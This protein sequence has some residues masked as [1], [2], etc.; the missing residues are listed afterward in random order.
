MLATSRVK[1]LGCL[2]ASVVAAL[3][4]IGLAFAQQPPGRT[5]EPPAGD[6]PAAGEGNRTN[7]REGGI[8]RTLDAPRDR[9]RESQEGSEEGA[10]SAEMQPRIKEVQPR[11]APPQGDWKLGVWANNTDTGVVITRVGPRSAAASAG[12]ENGDRIV[13]IGGYQVGYVG[14][15]LF[16]LG[17]E[18]QR[19]ADSRGRVELLVQNVRNKQLQNVP[20]Q[21]DGGRRPSF[22]VRP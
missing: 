2:M 22:P 18:L 20:V 11:F 8:P 1:I 19:Q 4:S 12:L 17:Y 9:G 14:D 16:P 13:A 10:P 21:L 3:F 15:L 5:R 7:R 6:S